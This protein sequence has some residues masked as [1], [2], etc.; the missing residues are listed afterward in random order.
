M[1]ATG[2]RFRLTNESVSMFPIKSQ[3]PRRSGIDLHVIES[4]IVP[5]AAI[6]RKE[7]MPLSS[8]IELVCRPAHWDAQQSNRNQQRPQ[9]ESWQFHW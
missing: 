7:L 8:P 5:L 3:C 4:R 9:P 6:F 1:G 2:L